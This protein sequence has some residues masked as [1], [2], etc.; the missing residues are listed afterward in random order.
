M[1]GDDQ[2]ILRNERARAAAVEPDGRLLNVFEPGVGDLEAVFFL[3]LFAR[4]IGEE[5]H[6]FVGVEWGKKRGHSKAG[7][8]EEEP[9]G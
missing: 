1:V 4:R 3:E 7:G 5:P 9:P 6:A 2:A 8:R